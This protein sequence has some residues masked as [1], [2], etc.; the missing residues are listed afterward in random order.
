MSRYCHRCF[1]NGKSR[2]QDH[3]DIWTCSRRTLH[4]ASFRW[5]LYGCNIRVVH[6]YKLYFFYSLPFAEHCIINAWQAKNIPN[7]IKIFISSLTGQELDAVIY[8]I[9]HVC[10][11]L[12]KIVFT[13]THTHTHT[14]GSEWGSDKEIIKNWEL[15]SLLWISV[16]LNAI[17]ILFALFS[18]HK[19]TIFFI[20][21]IYLFQSHSQCESQKMDTSF[22]SLVCAYEISL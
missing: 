10:H 11:N 20:V 9:K 22:L 21:F 1:D 3:I 19:C 5:M 8:A 15:R 2:F 13:S 4:S 14:H 16:R 7:R 18:L 17:K 12:I 6:N